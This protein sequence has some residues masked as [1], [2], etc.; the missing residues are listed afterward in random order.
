MT[1]KPCDWL[2]TYKMCDWLKNEYY[3]IVVVFDSHTKRT[4]TS[5]TKSVDRVT[6]VS[7]VTIEL[8]I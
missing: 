3:N 8:G 1:Y 7:Y 6:V 4:Q 5:Y 2:M